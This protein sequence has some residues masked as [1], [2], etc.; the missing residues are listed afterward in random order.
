MAIERS[1]NQSIGGDLGEEILPLLETIRGKEAETT[2]R[3]AGERQAAQAAIKAAKQRACDII[4]NAE[5]RGKKEGEAQR[6]AILEESERQAA[7]IVAQAKAEAKALHCLSR[8]EMKTT[9]NQVIKI[10]TGS[11]TPPTCV[12]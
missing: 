4:A 8:E 2:R 1:L 7:A 11:N 12:K 10:V 3:M 5:A 6:Q 9:V